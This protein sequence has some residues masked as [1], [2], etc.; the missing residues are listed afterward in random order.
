MTT[1]SRVVDG[2]RAILFAK[3]HLIE[4]STDSLEFEILEADARTL[5]SLVGTRH[6][7]S[8]DGEEVFWGELVSLKPCTSTARGLAMMGDK[9]A[10]RGLIRIFGNDDGQVQ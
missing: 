10:L 8:C 9:P 4:E 1:I 3:V 2:G 5:Q 7:L 6:L